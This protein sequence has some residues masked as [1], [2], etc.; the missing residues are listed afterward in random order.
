MHPR[1]DRLLAGFQELEKNRV[2]Y[3]ENSEIP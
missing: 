1:G 2:N 3:P